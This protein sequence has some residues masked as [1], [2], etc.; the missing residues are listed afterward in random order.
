MLH[1]MLDVV[2]VDARRRGLVLC[3]VIW[4]GLTSCSSVKAPTRSA[5]PPEPAAAV[6]YKRVDVWKFVD[7]EQAPTPVDMQLREHFERRFAHAQFSE[8]YSCLAREFANFYGTY[9]AAPEE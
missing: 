3:A 6:A 9:A 8:E 5:A 2:M 4:L 1:G 7:L